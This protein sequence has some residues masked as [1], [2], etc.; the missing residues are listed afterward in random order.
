MFAS[1]LYLLSLENKTQ[2]DFPEKNLNFTEQIR[3]ALWS[4][5][6]M[7]L[8]TVI[9]VVCNTSQ[10]IIIKLYQTLDIF[11]RRHYTCHH[12]IIGFT[13]CCVLFC[14]YFFLLLK[15]KKGLLHIE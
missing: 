10:I 4:I 11:Q 2:Q 5:S 14:A 15:H 12:G 13:F 6:S 3:H 9:P 7:S 8:L 1:G